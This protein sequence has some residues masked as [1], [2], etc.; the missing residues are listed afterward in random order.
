MNFKAKIY[1]NIDESLKS[2]HSFHLQ[3]TKNRSFVDDYGKWV[4]IMNDAPETYIY[5]NAVK[6]YQ[7][8]FDNMLMKL[9]QPT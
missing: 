8:A 9:Y 3:M 6:A 2:E 4:A 5:K 7:E 1:E